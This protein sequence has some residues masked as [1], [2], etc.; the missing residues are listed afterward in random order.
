MKSK[1]EITKNKLTKKKVFL[2]LKKKRRI[3]ESTPRFLF[4]QLKVKFTSKYEFF[5]YI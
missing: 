2:N 5:I 3:Y 1:G 4:M